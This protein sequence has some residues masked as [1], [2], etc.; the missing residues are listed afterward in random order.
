M[1]EYSYQEVVDRVDGL[2]SVS[3]L[4]KWRL[5][6]ESFTENKFKEIRIKT[7]RNSYSKAHIF[8]QDDIDHLQAIA[9]KKSAMGLG[10]AILSVYGITRD[11]ENQKSIEEVLS[12][13]EILRMENEERYIKGLIKVEYE[14]E[15]LLSRVETL[16]NKN[17]EATSKRRGF[18]KR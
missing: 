18:F 5:R 8:T 3:T 2:N 9:N 13:I 11:K 15:S 12:D 14:L 17:V 7:G 4:K 16:E 10:K 6:I 1:R